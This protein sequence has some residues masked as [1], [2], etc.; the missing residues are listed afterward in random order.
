LAEDAAERKLAI[1][2]ERLK[3]ELTKKTEEIRRQ[4]DA[5]IQRIQNEFKIW[6]V[7]LPP[8]PPLL[9]GLIVFVKRRLREREGI[10][11]TRMR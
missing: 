6:A 9:V 8:I 4:M 7:V 2:R 5:K 3:T 10:A 11:K 1:T